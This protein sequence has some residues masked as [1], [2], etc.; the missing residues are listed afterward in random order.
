MKLPMRSETDG[1]SPTM[2]SHVIQL[3]MASTLERLVGC[4]EKVS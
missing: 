4:P 2:H 3:K 1:V